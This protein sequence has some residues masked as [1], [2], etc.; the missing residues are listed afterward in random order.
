MIRLEDLNIGGKRVFIRADLNVPIKEGR[1]SND[2]RIKASLKTIEKVVEE[3]CAV[4]VMSHLGRP[5]EGE[6]DKALSLAPVAARLGE[7]LD[8]PVQLLSEIEDS[9]SIDNGKVGLLENVRFLKGETKNSDE[10]GKRMAAHCDVFVMDAFGSAHRAHASTNSIAN[11]V[12][13]VCAGY[14]MDSELS[15]LN[16]ALEAPKKP[17]FAIL[18]GAK[19]SSKLML[20]ERLSEFAENIF[21]GGGILNTF[22]AASEFEIGRS[23]YEQNMLETAKN[24]MAKTTIPIPQDVIVSKAFDEKA[25][26]IVRAVEDIR[27]DEMVMDIGPETARTW[28][29]RLHEAG[30][31]IWNGPLGVFEFDQFGEGTREIAE[32]IAKS[33]AFSLAGGGDTIA[34]IDK[35]EVSEGI[36]YISTGG[37]AF[38]EFVEGK[39][40]P[41][42]EILKKH[43]T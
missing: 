13:Q 40:L 27:E 34:A 26:G 11:H 8:R 7:L 38:M 23:L 2:A 29:L 19:V 30:T 16:S 36:S 43:R 10:L 20:L 14:L 4:T 15:A 41:G 9:R 12:D 35:Y 3:N 39:K 22:I 17:V 32:G 28:A 25:T 33:E 5:K 1:I 31:I 6:F 21:V 37:G 42:V 18:G 24:I